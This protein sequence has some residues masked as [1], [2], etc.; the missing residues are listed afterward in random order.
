MNRPQFPSY[1][2]F[3]TLRATLQTFLNNRVHPRYYGRAIVIILS[4]LVILPFNL[5]ERLL[6]NRKIKQVKLDQ[7]PLC[8]L[9]HDRS[10]TTHLMTLLSMDDQFAFVRSSQFLLPDACILFDKVITP[11]LDKAKVKRPM[12]NM[13]VVGDTPQDE[14]LP[15]VKLTAYAD[16]QKYCFPADYQSFTTSLVKDFTPRSKGFWEWKEHTIFVCKKAAYMMKR[17][18]LLLRNHANMAR[19]EAFLDVYP[20][21]KFLHIKRNPYRLI[22][23]LM[24]LHKQIVS[25]YTLQEY[26]DQQ[27]EDFTFFQYKTFT[28]GFARDKHLIGE[29]NL[30]EIAYEDLA[31]NPIETLRAV[32]S[33]LN[34]RP[35]Y[36]VEGRLKTYLDTIKHYETNSY[37]EDLVLKE[38]INRELGI[39]FET[40]GYDIEKPSKSQTKKAALVS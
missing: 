35:F 28:E 13:T 31:A 5:L 24:N 29:E 19:L 12:D 20:N 30:I 11:A 10:G 39:A 14:E 21:A 27:L 34:L 25:R 36:E 33:K 2:A 22:P 4:S 7:E 15:L 17:N 40:F 23:S 6:F 37:Q 9:G 32:Y 26:S 1:L 38:R 8:I 3:S 16:L 18:R